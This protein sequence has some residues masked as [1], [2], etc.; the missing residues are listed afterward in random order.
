MVAHEDFDSPSNDTTFGA[1]DSHKIVILY[2]QNVLVARGEKRDFIYFK[3]IL[4]YE[5]STRGV[6][7]S[8][9]STKVSLFPP[10]V[11]VLIYVVPI[12]QSLWIRTNKGHVFVHCKKKRCFTEPVLSGRTFFSFVRNYR[13]ILNSAIPH[14]TTNG[15]CPGHR[16]RE[17]SDFLMCKKRT[18]LF[19]Q[20][21]LLKT[22]EYVVWTCF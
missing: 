13:A 12:K 11:V 5:G 7:G 22:E 10:W 4:K 16:F 2:W 3:K 18:L 21:Y 9:G 14:G 8:M 1:S 19:D 6:R 17:I 20:K 15:C